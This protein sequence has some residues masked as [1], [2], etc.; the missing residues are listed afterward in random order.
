MTVTVTAFTAAR[1]QA[2]EDAAIVS[3]AINGSGDL[4]L[5]TFGGT[6]INAGSVLGPTTNGI[7]ICT[8]T[9][10]PS[11][12]FEGMAIYETNT[13]R[14]YIYDGSSWVF[15]DTLVAGQDRVLPVSTPATGGP[16]TG[17]ATTLATINI[18]ARS[19]PYKLECAAFWSGYNTDDGD[20]FV[21][22]VKV[23]GVTKGDISQRHSGGANERRVYSIPCTNHVI[24]PANTPCDVT[25]EGARDAGSGT[26]I[27]EKPGVLRVIM[28]MLNQ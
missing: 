5:T 15:W 23:D 28:Y 10:R 17:A 22:N 26:L 12:P 16:I 6:D 19:F 11:S 3:G 21:F 20:T 14:T 7:T 9:T 18:S 2:I 1:S 25:F 8:S 24:I 13:N 27:Q 4:I